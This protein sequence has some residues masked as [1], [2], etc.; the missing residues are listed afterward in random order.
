DDLLEALEGLNVAMPGIGDEFGRLLHGAIVVPFES[1]WRDV[2]WIIKGIQSFID[3]V[4]RQAP[5][6]IEV[7]AIPTFP[8]TGGGTAPTTGG[9]GAGRGIPSFAAGGIVT[10]PTLAIVGESGP[11]MIIP[12]N[13]INKGGAMQF[14]TNVSINVNDQEA[15]IAQAMRAFEAQLRTS[16]RSA[17]MGG[18]VITQGA[19]GN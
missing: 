10:Q 11:E 9:G 7:G 3:W 5:I 14:N 13:T 8:G 18:S 4:K 15:I 2:E 17:S 6:K 16:L 1:L 19:Y 12:M